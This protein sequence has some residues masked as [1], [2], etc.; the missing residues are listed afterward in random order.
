MLY[1]LTTLS[2]SLL[3]QDTMSDGAR[4][5]VSDTNA[6]GI[7]LGSWH[8]E[9]GEIGQ[10]IVLRK[11]TTM[12]ELQHERERAYMDQRPFH[13]GNLRIRIDMKSYALFPFLP[14]VQPATFGKFYEL[15]RYWLK[16]GGI[17]PTIAAREKAEGRR[18]GQSLHIA[19][20][21]KHVR[22]R[23]PSSHHPHLGILKPRGAY[24]VTGAS[25][26]RRAMAA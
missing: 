26:C 15:R 7:V 23:R 20:G 2:C 22:T 21:R 9:I 17:A 6:T 10:I 24:D 11:F 25:L 8:T 19:S 3:E 16:P 14:E 18:P 12:S 4:R 5:W 13:T 1:E